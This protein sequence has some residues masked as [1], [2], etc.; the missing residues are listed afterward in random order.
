M[1]SCCF[2]ASACFAIFYVS[3]CLC[4]S[5]S[6]SLFLSLSLSLVQDPVPFALFWI[7]F[8]GLARLLGFH[9]RG[10]L[11]EWI[12]QILSYLALKLTLLNVFFFFHSKKNQDIS[13]LTD[14]YI[15][16]SSSDNFINTILLISIQLYYFVVFIHKAYILVYQLSS[17]ELSDPISN[18]GRNVFLHANVLRK[19]MSPFLPFPQLL[20][21]KRTDQLRQL[22]Y[23]KEK[24]WIQTNEILIGKMCTILLLS[25]HQKSVARPKQAFET[26]ATILGEN[27]SEFKPSVVVVVGDRS[28]GRPEDSLFNSYYTKLLGS[29][30][31]L[32][33]SFSTLPLIRTL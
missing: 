17:F 4:L 8:L 9:I 5:L 22:V 10:F 23:E 25:A 27:R 11:P 18:P 13:L 2:T 26:I 21:N 31:L 12:R 7:I 28:R 19:G 32:T 1:D 16:C 29:A 30:L 24:L 14:L 3:L 6:L 15:S 20:I 33:L